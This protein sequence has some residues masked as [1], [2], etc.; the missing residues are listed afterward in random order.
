MTEKELEMK[1]R[2]LND[3]YREGD[4]QVS[5]DVFDNLVGQLRQMNPSNPWFSKGIQDKVPAIRKEKLPIPM[6]SLEK[7]KTPQEV[8][9]WIMSCG[10]K[11]DDVL[12]ITAK[13]DG[14]SLCVN[15]K[16]GKA[17]TRGDG[18]YGQNCTGHFEMMGN[19][20][21]DIYEGD[22]ECDEV[23][24]TFGEAIFEQENFLREIKPGTNYK[25][26]RNAVGG[27]LNAEE[28]SVF[29]GDVKYIRYGTDREEWS[30]ESQL[31]YINESIFDGIKTSYVT[32]NAVDILKSD[33]E[34]LSKYFDHLYRTLAPQFKCD[35]IVIEV[36]RSVT[37]QNLGRL[38]NGNPR[39]AIAYK[40]PQWSEREETI[41]HDIEWE[42]SK[43]G[44]LCPVGL[45]E[46]VDLCGATVERCTLY[47][48]R[49][50]KENHCCQGA[51]V[52]ICRS[53]DVI[54]KHLQTLHFHLGIDPIPSVCPICSEKTVWDSKG[55]T[56]RCSN[57]EC[58][59][60]A[61]SEIVYFFSIMKVEDFGRPTIKKFFDYGLKSVSAI[62]EASAD[63]MMK[64]NGIGNETISSLRKQFNNILDNSQSWSQLTTALNCYHGLIGE[65]TCQNIIDAMG[66]KTT[67]DM[68][69]LY[70][71][72][73]REPD[74]VES[75][76]VQIKGV[77]NEI[78]V[79]FRKGVV[80]FYHRDDFLLWNVG[81]YMKEKSNMPTFV[82]SGFRDK[83]LSE[84]AYK[85]GWEEVSSLTK[86]TDLLV[87]LERD[88]N[89]SKAQRARKYGTRIMSKE[90]F[91]EMIYADKG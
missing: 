89:S 40:D 42:V 41:L 35:G 12:V 1:I 27:I 88:S 48:A 6:F 61:L 4:P 32:V 17:W 75:S 78:A 5:D 77:G 43:D 91:M 25:A 73:L 53:G 46:P 31:D 59:G 3:S 54:P 70:E 26:A 39:Y 11:D 82:M 79:A 84:E 68:D 85:R 52:V 51:E 45:I 86:T 33:A 18:T 87:T 64:I 44:V 57:P 22:D 65:R 28:L 47:N 14:I 24:Y 60:K 10:L 30:K 37:R 90:E 16:E 36:N 80:E 9:K 71:K 19:S 23:T 58:D 49:Y 29:L 81:I 76:L 56:L 50:V 21:W 62:M 8:V 7:V 74:M 63:R 66:I 34:E 15:E 67:D 13:Y 2:S 55:I 69:N 20:A 38:P 83:E 72:C